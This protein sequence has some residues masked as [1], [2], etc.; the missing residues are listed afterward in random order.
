MQSTNARHLSSALTIAPFA[1]V[2]WAALMLGGCSRDPEPAPP[3][4]P[5]TRAPLVLGALHTV[6]LLSAVPLDPVL[7][8]GGYQP[9]PLPANYPAAIG[10]EALLWDVPEATAGGAVYWRSTAA[11]DAPHL[12]VLQ[13]DPLPP[14][15]PRDSA[16]AKAFFVDVLGTQPPAWTAPA[17]TPESARLHVFTYFTASVLEARDRLRAQQADIVAGPVAI[18][19]PHF[20]D[21]KVISVRVPGGAIVELVE[22]VTQ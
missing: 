21:H 20:G 12:R 18:S 3:A 19:T 22:N 7:S 11:P 6:T 9:L 16:A 4:A 17:G 15:P 10:V 8:E 14:Q 13:Q 2:L 5:Q 1:L